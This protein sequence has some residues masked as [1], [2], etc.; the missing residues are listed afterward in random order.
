MTTISTDL[1]IAVSQLSYDLPP[2]TMRL[3]LAISGMCV[4]L[5]KS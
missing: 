4:A 2:I 5:Q 3:P 1:L